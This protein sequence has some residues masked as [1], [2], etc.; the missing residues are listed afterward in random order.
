VPIAEH[1]MM[2]ATGAANYAVSQA[3]TLAYIPSGV[4]VQAVPRSLVWVDRRGRE[5]SL[6]APLRA[7]G[8]PRLSPDG[9]RIVANLHDQN[10]D[11]WIWDIPH[12][13]LTRLTFDPAIDAMPVWTLTQTPETATAIR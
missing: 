6:G 8:N 2:K 13:N 5:Q 4:D 3:G 1:V 10:V 7:Y 11:L 9:K 12:E